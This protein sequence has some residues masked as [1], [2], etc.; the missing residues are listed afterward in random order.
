MTRVIRARTKRIAES[1]LIGRLSLG[2]DGTV[3]GSYS[4]RMRRNTASVDILLDGLVLRRL[5]RRVRAGML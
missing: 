5:C 4:I 1:E 3:S 2:R